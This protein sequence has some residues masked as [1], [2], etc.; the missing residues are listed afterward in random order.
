MCL[1]ETPRT[2]RCCGEK[3]LGITA[4]HA[5]GRMIVEQLVLE[6]GFV[7]GSSR[8]MIH[9]GA[10]PFRHRSLVRSN[11]DCGGN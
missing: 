11:R 8:G 3:A 5:E 2:L 6:W 1:G 9:G 4:E 10:H 7:R